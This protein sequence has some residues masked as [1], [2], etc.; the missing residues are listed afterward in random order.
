MLNIT[1]RKTEILYNT[2]NKDRK[3]KKKQKK[4]QIQ[5]FIFG[6]NRKKYLKEAEQEKNETKAR[7][8]ILTRM[9]NSFIH[10]CILS[11]TLFYLNEI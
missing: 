11:F 9:L 5:N 8:P 2:Q 7:L 3:K 1:N 4:H 6:H 10:S